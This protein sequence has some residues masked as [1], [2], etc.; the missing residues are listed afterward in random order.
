[1]K[2]KYL[3]YDD[4]QLVPKY[5]QIYSRFLIA[6][7]TRVTKNYSIS[8]PIIAAPMDTVCEFD[9][10]F[11]LGNMGG[12]GCIHRFMSIEQQADIVKKLRN[13]DIKPIMAAIGVQESDKTRA[14]I[15]SNAGVNIILID[16]AHGHHENV[17]KM[18]KWCKDNLPTDVDVVAGNIATSEAA[19]DLITAGVDGLRI[20]VGGGSLCSTRLKTGFGVPNV[21]CIEDIYESLKGWNH[22][23]LWADGG[24]RNSGDIAKALAVGA[25]C[26]MLGSMLAGTDE[27]PGKV[28]EKNN[29][30]YKRYRGS[31][32][33]ETKMLHGQDVR[34]IE[35]ESTIIPYKG[36]VKYIIND[37]T[38]GLRSAL[39]Y[40]GATTLDEYIPD[41]IIITNAGQT[42]AR[43]HLLG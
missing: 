23:P 9:M 28:I 29:M 15:L 22:V 25:D 18:I 13:N 12:V 36:G 3:T 40:G 30:L 2:Q 43:P 1:M 19:H 31:A 24:I 6:L 8:I 37:I 27:A 11:K 7:S 39:S 41:Y 26:V 21:T 32:S 5:S 42:E 20:G 4:I 10:A 16:V 35:G 14:E 34:N 38:D 33:I 17:I